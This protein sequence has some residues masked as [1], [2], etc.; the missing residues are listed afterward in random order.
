M[1]F[2]DTPGRRVDRSVG[3]KRGSPRSPP[4]TDETVAVSWVFNAPF[5][6]ASYYGAD[7][8]ITDDGLIVPIRAGRALGV[9]ARKY[10][11]LDVD[12]ISI[13]PARSGAISF[14]TAA[15]TACARRGS[16]ALFDSRV[17]IQVPR[18]YAAHS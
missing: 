13:R 15:P 8:Y 1:H 16:R 5:L 4:I 10:R 18:I 9:C 14:D 3:V 7:A 11:S 12:L 17:T 6:A 2:A